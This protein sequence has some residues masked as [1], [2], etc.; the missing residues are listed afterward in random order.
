MEV[1]VFFLWGKQMFHGRVVSEGDDSIRI[2]F[3]SQSLDLFMVFL[4]DF[5]CVSKHRTC[6]SKN[7]RVLLLCIGGGF[8]HLCF[9]SCKNDCR[10]NP[11]LT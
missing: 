10:D 4:F 3:L 1:D 8:T 11:N 9:F 2:F 5:F 6:K 7:F